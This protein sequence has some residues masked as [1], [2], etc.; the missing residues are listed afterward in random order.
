MSWG[1]A[2]PFATLKP[3]PT[4]TALCERQS[5]SSWMSNWT[6]RPGP[7]AHFHLCSAALAF[8]HHRTWLSRPFCRPLRPPYPWPAAFAG[9]HPRFWFILLG[10]LG[11]RR[12]RHD[13]QGLAHTARAW[14][15][16]LDQTKRE[17][18]VNALTTARDVAR[19]HSASTPETA[20]LFRGLPSSRDGTRLTNIELPIVVGLRLGMPVAAEEYF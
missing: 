16:P 15:R 10:S 3:W 7:K 14:Q 18:L 6:N 5:N 19:L 1:P 8:A 12:R 11:R 20:A 4:M 2:P 13:P 17:R 9:A